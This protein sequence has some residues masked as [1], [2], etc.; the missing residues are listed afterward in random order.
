M[1]NVFI[2]ENLGPSSTILH[3]TS[4]KIVGP[5][6]RGGGYGD[7]AGGGDE[8]PQAESGWVIMSIKDIRL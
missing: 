6:M 1:K 8:K 4:S 5:L 2:E 7:R 3:F